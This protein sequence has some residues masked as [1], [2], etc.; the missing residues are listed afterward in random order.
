M[1]GEENGAGY[2]LV[3]GPSRT[4]TML[5]VSLPPQLSFPAISVAAALLLA[6]GTSGASILVPEA[7]SG[8]IFQGF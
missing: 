4:E 2:Q 1:E 8:G 5:Q 6:T 7:L 3:N